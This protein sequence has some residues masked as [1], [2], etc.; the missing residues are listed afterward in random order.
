MLHRIVIVCCLLTLQQSTHAEVWQRH[1][2]D[3]SSVGADGVRLADF[4]GDGKLDFVTGWE[5]GGITRVYLQPSNDK[6]K[7]PWPA[8]TVGNTKS[9]EDAVAVDLD[10]DGMLDVVSSTEGKTRTLFV[11]WSPSDQKDL[12]DGSRWKTA[13]IPASI[14]AQAWMFALPLQIDGKRGVDFVT[15]SKNPNGAV[16]WWQSPENPRDLAKW[17]YHRLAKAGWIMSL[18]ARDLDQDGDQ[19]IL[20]SDR[21]TETRG[22]KWLRCPA[23]EKVTVANAWEAQFI[24]GENKELLFGA[25]AD[26]DRDGHEDVVMATRNG[27]LDLAQRLPSRDLVNEPKWK[28]HSI[29]NPFGLEHGKSVAVADFDRDGQPEIG[30]TLR[31]KPVDGPAVALM[32]CGGDVW[33]T[34]WKTH[35]IGGGKGSKFDL[36]E[37]IDIDSDGDLDLLTCEEVSNLGVFWYENPTY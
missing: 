37:P 26:L 21:K 3:D 36:L 18:F 24:G 2:I 35:D 17:K 34:P 32:Q 28:W 20:F 23:T 25:L 29:P 12:L 7:S 19:D 8:V 13:P 15:G 6:L 16:G 22:L 10:G 9:V 30:V 33:S 14:G 1:T 5:Q 11:H 31:S 4:N 27:T